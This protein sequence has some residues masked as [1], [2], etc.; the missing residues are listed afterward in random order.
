M[1]TR[2]TGQRFRQRKLSMK[3]VL[4][5]VAEEDFAS[6]FDDA[7]RPVQKVETGVEKGEET[8]VIS[9]TAAGKKATLYIPTPDVNPC[10]KRDFS[11]AYRPDFKQPLS[12]IKSSQTVE[13]LIGPAYCADREDIESVER[14][15]SGIHLGLGD[16]PKRRMVL[17]AFELLFTHFEERAA[18]SASDPGPPL[19]FEQM[20]VGESK[21]V[22]QMVPRFAKDL[23]FIKNVY[24]IWASKRSKNG[25]RPLMPTLKFERNAETDDADPYVCF[26]RREI[27]Q[28]RRTRGGLVQ[29]QDKLKRLRVEVESSRQLQYKAAEREETAK[30]RLRVQRKVVTERQN[31]KRLKRQLGIRES[32]EDLMIDRKP[33]PK[34]KPK[35]DAT[36]I[37]R[38]TVPGMVPKAPLVRADG[39]PPDSDLV[40]LTEEKA[41]KDAA[42]SSVIQESMLKHRTWNTDWVDLTWRPITPPTDQAAAKPGYRTAVTE[43][44][45]SPPS[46]VS[47]AEDVGMTDGGRT[48]KTTISERSNFPI[49]YASPAPESDVQV[50]RASYRRRVGRGGRLFVDR[51]GV[52]Q[53]VRDDA[54]RSPLDS[55]ATERLADAFYYDIDSDEEADT[56]FADAYDEW[57][58]KYR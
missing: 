24:E 57:N 31:L 6:G 25:N 54:P 3:Q 39:R 17:E 36:V 38:G 32:D 53:P 15:V 20:G 52:R 37:Q 27:R 56:Y 49:R 21:Y 4:S 10:R 16:T 8:A 34:P 48:P 43:F 2:A 46:S 26:R 14:V 45:P 28:V 51:R 12:F 40:Q 23:E 18:E 41:R 35:I 42:I 50:P 47:D 11:A 29:G 19:P 7:Q 9:A 33:A 1:A 58:I 13:D 55:P 30:E 44:L 5:I 22:K